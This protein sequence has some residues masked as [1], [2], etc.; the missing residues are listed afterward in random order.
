MYHTIAL[1]AAVT[2]MASAAAAQDEPGD[3]SR[4]FTAELLAD[5][6]AR[7]SLLGSGPTAGH[8]G[9][10]FLASSDGNFRLQIGGEI[11]FRYYG[12]IE[13]DDDAGGFQ[14]Q[15]TRLD[16]RGHVID[17]KL[18]YRILTNIDRSTGDLTL[19]DAYGEYEVSDGFKVRWGQFK[20]P[21]DREF[22]AT[23]PTQTQTIERSLVSS[24]F[25]LDRSQGVQLGYEADRWRVFGAFSDGR[26]AANTAY[27]DTI[28]A[29]FAVSGRAELRLGE[30]GWRQFRDQTA[31]RGDKFGV[32]LGGGLH[33]QQDGST[34]AP[35]SAMGTVDLFQYTADASVEN[36]GWNLLGAVTGR[37]IDDANDSLH[38]FGLIAQGGVFVSEHAELFAR[39]THIFP[40]DSRTGGSDDFAAI[41]AGM[42]WYF[43]PKSHAVKLSAEVTYYPD[44]QADS[45]SII[46]A[47]D[48]GVGLLSDSD[49]GQFGFVMQMQLLF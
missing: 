49:G 13:T 3:T 28:E 42:H 5:A 44:T 8:D 1:L 19:Q 31:F 6:S 21:F 29:D 48:T 4:A 17:P 11:Q 36:D 23:S 9:R 22:Y 43:I 46:R 18:T 38:D 25:R 39:Y 41:T 33:W 15:R 2:G 45:A 37:V 40:D 47:P 34:G 24:V 16:F 35:S 7:T 14:L 10:F 26:R 20:L 27:T 30:A 32:L 12:N